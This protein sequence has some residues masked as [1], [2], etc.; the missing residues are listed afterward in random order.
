MF[1][2][3]KILNKNNIRMGKH[4]PMFHSNRKFHQFT[5]ES[6]Y[7][8][9]AAVGLAVVGLAAENQL[10]ADIVLKSLVDKAVPLDQAEA[11]QTAAARLGRE[12][13]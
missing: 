3:R 6:P 2:R 7:R 10:V 8:T 9:T 11:F 5:F 13:A 1:R 4:L 12:V